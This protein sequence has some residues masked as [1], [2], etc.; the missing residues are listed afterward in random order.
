MIAHSYDDF[1]FA[2]YALDLQSIDSNRNIGSFA[3]L[4][5][6]LEKPSTYSLTLLFENARLTPLYEAVLV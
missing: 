1:K 3:W 2:H 5:Y 4:F 6:D